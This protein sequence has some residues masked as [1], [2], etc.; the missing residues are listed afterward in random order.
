VGA[1]TQGPTATAT[2]AAAPAADVHVRRKAKR[3]AVSARDGA[4]GPRARMEA[5]DRVFWA[6]VWP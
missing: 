1:L 6:L 2:A 5:N 3:C 4:G